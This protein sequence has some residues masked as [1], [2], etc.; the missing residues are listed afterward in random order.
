MMTN[1]EKKQL[2]SL[3]N[4][5]MDELAKEDDSNKRMRKDEKASYWECKSGVKTQYEHARCIVRK[6]SV[7]INKE[8]WAI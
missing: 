2:V 6:L 8:M 5:Y 7:E 3:L 4:K 1:A